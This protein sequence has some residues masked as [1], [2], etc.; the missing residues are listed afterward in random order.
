MYSFQIDFDYLFLIWHVVRS[1]SIC[2]KACFIKQMLSPPVGCPGIS[3]GRACGPC[4]L[5]PYQ[6]PGFYP[7]PPLTLSLPHPQLSCQNKGT[8]SLKSFRCEN[9][10]SSHWSSLLINVLMST[11]NI[12]TG[13]SWAEYKCE[14]A[15]NMQKSVFMIKWMFQV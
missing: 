12:H 9:P 1:I 15:E 8:K 13:I 10:T 6:Q 4:R 5:G 2:I 7:P 14:T 11:H 3:P